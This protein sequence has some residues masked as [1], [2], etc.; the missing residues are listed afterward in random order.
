VTDAVIGTPKK[1]EVGFLSGLGR[2]TKPQDLMAAAKPSR[3][4][5]RN[6]TSRPL[7]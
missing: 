2:T 5:K 3:D 1:R 4:K 6:L 7:A